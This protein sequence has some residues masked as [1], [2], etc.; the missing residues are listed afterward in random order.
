MSRSAAGT[1]ACVVAIAAPALIGMPP[2]AEAQN[3]PA[4]PVRIIVPFTPGSPND[5]MARLLAQHLQGRLG[6]AVVID[7]K[8]GGGTTIGSKAAAAAPPDGH[9]LLFAS[10][11]LVIEPILNKQVEYDPQKDFTP[12][13]FIARNS[14]LLTVAAQVPANSVAEF[15]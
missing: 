11:A 2:V 13:A 12:I 7:N 5:V 10:S 15:V 6:Q 3:F 1:F 9:T 4:K 14:S 8:P